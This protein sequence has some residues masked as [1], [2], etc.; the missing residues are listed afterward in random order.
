MFRVVKESETVDSRQH[1]FLLQNSSHE[2][3]YLNVETRQ[4]LLRIENSWNTAIVTSVIKLGVR[5]TRRR[6]GNWLMVNHV[7]LG[8]FI[9]Q[10][11]TFGVTAVGKG[12]CGLTLD[13]QTGFTLNEGTD[14]TVIWQFKFS[15]LRGSS[16]DGK[17][18]LKLHFQDTDTRVIETKV[19]RWRFKG[20]GEEELID[21]LDVLLQ[22]L[23]CQVLQSL[24]FCMHAFLTAKV[25]SVDPAFLSSIH[26]S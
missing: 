2:P 6:L 15:Q 22:E 7:S 11:K 4:E 25:A 1:C 9:Q 19:R 14:G 21:W 3:K 16:D 13:W 17:S 12:C 5:R 18:K 20:K 23:E 8:L 10:R 26:Q 24:L